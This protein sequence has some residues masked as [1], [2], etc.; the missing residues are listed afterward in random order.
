MPRKS[1]NANHIRKQLKEKKF[2]KPK[3]DK[4]GKIFI[5]TTALFNIHRRA[6][7]RRA[8]GSKKKMALDAF[9]DKVGGAHVKAIGLKGT[10]FHVNGSEYVKS[11]K[12]H[13]VILPAYK[14]REG[15]T[16]RVI[17]VVDDKPRVYKFP[18][19]GWSLANH[20][21]VAKETKEIADKIYHLVPA[22]KFKKVRR[23]MNIEFND[24][25]PLMKGVLVEEH[26][27]IGSGFAADR[28]FISKNLA[29]ESFSN[30]DELVDV[31]KQITK[32]VVKLFNHGIMYTDTKPE[33]FVREHKKDNE[34]PF[35]IVK[36]VDLDADYRTKTKKYKSKTEKLEVAVLAESLATSFF[37]L[38]ESKKCKFKIDSHVQ[39]QLHDT[40]I[41]ELEKNLSKNDF[42]S[43]QYYFK[44]SVKYT[45]RS[46]SLIQKLL[47]H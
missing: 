22:A 47:H 43:A 11:G 1:F 42:K 17:A 20:M 29:E 46:D 16:R 14:S 6:V 24:K 39:K 45:K 15:A 3:V 9:K 26:E 7:I 21:E 33:N 12:H 19:F 30:P 13:G 32:S 36:I 8:G 23:M 35:G 27:F 41:H 37:D 31:T 25:H 38:S 34:H 4:K 40:I 44:K 5:D 18:L 10:G 2:S 28:R